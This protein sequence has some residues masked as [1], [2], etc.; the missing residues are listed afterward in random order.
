MGVHEQL[1]DLFW[2]RNDD[3]IKSIGLIVNAFVE[4]C[5]VMLDFECEIEI[6][7]L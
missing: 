1:K 2:N 4:L 7:M 5:H 3:F 6:S